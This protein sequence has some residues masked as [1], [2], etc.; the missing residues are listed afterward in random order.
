MLY[1]DYRQKKAWN[2]ILPVTR[3]WYTRT[4]NRISPRK[5]EIITYYSMCAKNYQFL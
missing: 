4:Q 5:C 2:K 3:Y 1:F